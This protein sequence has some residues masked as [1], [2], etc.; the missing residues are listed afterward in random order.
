MDIS[1]LKYN[2]LD[3]LE[4]KPLRVRIGRRWLLI[5]QLPLREADRFEISLADFLIRWSAE[6]KGIKILDYGDLKS[7][8][9]VKAFSFQWRRLL[10]SN[11]RLLDDVIKLICKPHGFS[12][13]YFRKHATYDLVT[14]CF[15]A[16]QLLNYEAVKKNI[17]FLLKRAHIIQQSP[18]SLISS[19]ERT[20]GAATKRLKP[21]Y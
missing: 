10:K 20:D 6:M 18:T 16:S 5:R 17:E 21:R 14:Q 8:D 3:I 4:E 13:R 15:L 11:K 12:R 9:E 2:D 1:N 19:Q 7:N